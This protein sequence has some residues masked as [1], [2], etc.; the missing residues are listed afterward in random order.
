MKK[1][2]II[3]LLVIFG[4]SMGFMGISCKADASE[5]AEE[6]TE[7]VAAEEE[8]AEEEIMEETE[9]VTVVADATYRIGYSCYG[10]EIPWMVFYQEIFDELIANEYPNYEIIYH[11]AQYDFQAMADGL[12]TFISDDVDMIM[13]FALDNLPVLES[14]KKIQ[15]AGIPLFLTMDEP[16][17][18]SWEYMVA[19]S[20]L[21]PAEAGRVCADDLNEQLGGEGT[22]AAITPPKG[23]SSY[24]MYMTRFYN[25][26]EDIGS[27]L[28]LVAEE[29]GN[30]DPKQ[31]QEK[32]ADIL[33]RFPDIDGFYVTDDW[34]GSGIVIAAK[35]K[36]YEPGDF[37]ISGCGGAAVGVK[38]L[39]DGWYSVLVDQGP[40]LCAIQDAYL[41]KMILE[42]TGP[43]PF[44]SMVYQ[45]VL[46]QDDMEGFEPSW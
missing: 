7:E 5:T 31:A 25:R 32:A 16:A 23:S 20:G 15:A 43:V 28:E 34:M 24:E 2:L 46:T 38:D 40:R 30:W 8:V 39:A 4:T 37:V 21:S 35:E 17:Y 36:G 29:D 22:Y 42:G 18:E 14:Y 27:N 26:L 3:M 13:H 6:I 44:Y 9:E 12:E 1:T 41:M 10:W 33:T 45:R 19:F 11:D